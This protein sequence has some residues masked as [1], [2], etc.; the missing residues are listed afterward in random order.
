M[1]RIERPETP[2]NLYTTPTEPTICEE[3]ELACLVSRIRMKYL[4]RPFPLPPDFS[5][6][7]HTFKCDQYLFNRFKELGRLE[8]PI[9]T[10]EKKLDPTTV[11]TFCSLVP[12]TKACVLYQ[13]YHLSMSY[14][15]VR[16][17]AHI[18]ETTKCR[19]MKQAVLAMAIRQHLSLNRAPSPLKFRDE[20]DCLWKILKGQ[21]PPFS[22]KRFY[23]LLYPSTFYIP[24]GR[25]V[26]GLKE[27]WQCCLLGYFANP[28]KTNIGDTL[29][30]YLKL[31]PK[32]FNELL[33]NK[34]TFK[35]ALSEAMRWGFFKITHLLK[36]QKLKTELN[37]FKE[38]AYALKKTA[39]KVSAIDY[40]VPFEQG[41]MLYR[42]NDVLRQ[43][44]L[45]KMLFP[46]IESWKP[47]EKG[48]NHAKKMLM[49]WIQN[50]L[51]KNLKTW[52]KEGVCTLEHLTNE[53]YLTYWYD[54]YRKVNTFIT[55]E[56]RESITKTQPVERPPYFDLIE[57]ICIEE[58]IDK[59]HFKL[60][61]KQHLPLIEECLR[62]QAP[63]FPFDSNHAANILRHLPKN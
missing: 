48:H 19:E 2:V 24:P 8:Q 26:K 52:E 51:E 22:A 25:A 43:T 61:R 33:N 15:R 34:M 23:M 49:E 17:I 38:D 44:Q 54:P 42:W 11:T 29:R 40:S 50:N 63:L 37:D 16:R 10:W 53:M 30:P 27:H 62:T 12:S 32:I 5:L 57:W 59:G 18:L 35:S 4:G 1:I 21:S 14:L 55:K 31:A 41:P 39:S 45:Y 46:F 3:K 56:K 47:S 9:E 58:M 36:D 28:K 13:S 60:E 6:T 7:E 20:I